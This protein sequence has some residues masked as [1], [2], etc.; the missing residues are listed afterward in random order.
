MIEFKDHPLGIAVIDEEKKYR[1][2]FIKPGF[3]YGDEIR[4]IK[5]DARAFTDDEER[6]IADKLDELNG[7]R[8]E[9]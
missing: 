4:F 9:T 3:E 2:C 6:Q 8:N 1:G 5:A 7:E